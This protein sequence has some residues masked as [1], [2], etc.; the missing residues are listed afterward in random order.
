MD[1]LEDLRGDARPYLDDRAVGCIVCAHSWQ[2][3]GSMLDLSSKFQIEE[4]AFDP[5]QANM[6][7]T[8][9]SGHGVPCVEYRQ[10]VNTM[11]EPLKEVEG[12]I[13]SRKIAH[14]G[15]PAMTWMLS[16]VV[17]KPDEG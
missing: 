7:M 14:D 10:I 17:A 15:D 4:V 11:S 13:R 9:L 1:Y 5:W 16:N 6:L 2:A 3:T 8:E 12:L